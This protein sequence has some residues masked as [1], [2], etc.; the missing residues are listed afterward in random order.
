MRGRSWSAFF[1]LVWMVATRMQVGWH[2][3]TKCVVRKWN[4]RDEIR[5]EVRNE[6]G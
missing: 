4:S 6:V 1:T 2:G 3:T 5:N